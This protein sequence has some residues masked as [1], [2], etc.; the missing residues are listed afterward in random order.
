MRKLQLN[1]SGLLVYCLHRIPCTGVW[2]GFTKGDCALAASPELI[3]GTIVPIVLKLL[4]E[5][6]M[7]GYEIIKTVNER[8]GGALEWREGTLYPWLHRLE[9]D[10]LLRSEWQTAP[11]GR[12]RKYY[13][14]TRR[15]RA[16][17]VEKIEEWRLTSTAVNALLLSPSP[18]R[19]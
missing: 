4:D 16:A 6:P 1:T 10:G 9:S 19:A 7:Y 5:R 2:S 11:S 15:G 3:K 18:V 12:R 14:L 13:A 8:T 17:L